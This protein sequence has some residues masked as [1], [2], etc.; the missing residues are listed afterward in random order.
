[1]RLLPL[2]SLLLTA[3]ATGQ[4]LPN[5]IGPTRNSPLIVQASHATC[6]QLSTCGPIALPPTTT[7]YWAGGSAWS[8]SDSSLWVTT[9]QQLARFPVPGCTPAC[10]PI[11]CPKSSATAEATGM[12]MHDGLNQL[13]IIDSAGWIT[14]ATNACSPVVQ[15]Q[16]N[17]GLALAGFT[18][19]SAITID[20]L[21]GLVFYTTCNFA[22]GAGMLYVAPLSNPG[23]WFQAMPL[24]DCFTNPTLVTGIACDAGGARLFWTNGRGTMRWDYAYNPAGPS[25]SYT[26]GPCC[27]QVA[28][29]TDPFTDLSIR[30]GGATSVGAPCANGACAPCPMNHS[31]RNAP[32]LGSTLQLGLDF[33]QPGT[34]ALCA[35]DIGTCATGGPLI[36]PFC[37]QFL[38]PM[39]SAMIVLGPNTPVG[40]SPCLASTTWF[41]PLPGNPIFAGTP[42]T[43]QCVSLCSPSGTAMSNCLSYVLQ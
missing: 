6:T 43:S 3:V 1:M 33:A 31:L 42:L 11:P 24:A 27:I 14:S 34:L 13:F 23:A 2:A 17:T 16:W 21:R 36:A 15:N 32:L 28:P 38:I 4:T 25:V 19:T 39:S 20:E 22:T 18:A 37:G 35:V 9:G 10:G 5:L 26:P 7:F 8:S 30:W 41:L 29:F 40:G 12:D